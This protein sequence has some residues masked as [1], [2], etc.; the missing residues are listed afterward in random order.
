[1]INDTAG[2]GVLD[3][4]FSADRILSLVAGSIA[5]IVDSSPAALDTLK[6]LASALNNDASF[7]TT[8]AA[9]LGNRV[10]VDAVQTFTVEEQLQAR[11]NISSA[12]IASVSAAQFSADRAQAAA[13]AVSAAL[14]HTTLLPRYKQ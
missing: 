4:T 10:R 3:K 11:S 6:E 13:D 2:A 7:A 1:M 5:N 14:V 9:S 12:S 8:I